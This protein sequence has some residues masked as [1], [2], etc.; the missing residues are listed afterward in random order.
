MLLNS[1]PPLR[2]KLCESK[3][4]STHINIEND[5]DEKREIRKME[6][7]IDT[8]IKAMYEG[9][10]QNEKMNA[11]YIKITENEDSWK[12]FIPIFLGGLVQGKNIDVII[13]NFVANKPE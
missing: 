2:K 10:I 1:K 12:E 7:E 13:E 8:K 5:E 11:N 6:T 3:E 4:N 9:M